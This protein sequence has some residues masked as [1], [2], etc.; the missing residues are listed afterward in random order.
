MPHEKDGSGGNL[1][2]LNYNLESNK[3]LPPETCNQLGIV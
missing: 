3:Y 1:T 2:S